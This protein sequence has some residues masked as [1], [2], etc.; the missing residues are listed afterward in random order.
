MADEVPASSVTVLAIGTGTG[1]GTGNG[2][3]MQVVETPE[4]HKNV[5]I[6]FVT[7]LM[8]ITVGFVVTFLTVLLAVVAAAGTA[9]DLLP[10][11]DFRQLLE[12]SA[13]IAL[14]SACFN[15]L[16]DLLTLFTALKNK[17]PLLGV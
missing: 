1:D 15:L 3:P 17:F 4:G 12:K 14:S 2:T 6:K 13:T 16:K 10:F 5:A 7:P 8:A 9:P 11:N